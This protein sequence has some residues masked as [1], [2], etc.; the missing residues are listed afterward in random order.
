M[1]EGGLLAGRAGHSG[2]GAAARH[3]GRRRTSR[4]G[5]LMRVRRGSAWAQGQ[6]GAARL[7]AEPAHPQSRQP[8][9]GIL[10][11]LRMARRQLRPRRPGVAAGRR[12]A[13]VPG[14]DFPTRSRPR[15]SGTG[16]RPGRERW[17]AAP[18]CGPSSHLWVPEPVPPGGSA[19]RAHQRPPVCSDSVSVRI[20]SSAHTAVASRGPRNGCYGDARQL[21]YLRVSTCRL[22]NG[23]P[24][25]LRHGR[26]R[27]PGSGNA[28]RRSVNRPPGLSIASHGLELL[29]PGSWPGSRREPG[30][31]PPSLIASCPAKL[32]HGG[33]EL[34]DG[35][36]VTY[37]LARPR[38][39]GSGA[40]HAPVIGGLIG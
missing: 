18:P 35:G 10:S 7:G 26:Q 8:A 4:A 6:R 37:V 38:P 39:P 1:A 34:R 15:S 25:R 19:A 31:T 24:L 28:G 5:G 32:R 11:A 27:A 2:L 29:E 20:I 13:R 12:P 9:P 22:C 3:R 14:H 17:R 23:Q 36:G 30:E 40:S 16:P 21:A 33:A